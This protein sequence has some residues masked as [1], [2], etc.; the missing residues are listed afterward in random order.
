MSTKWQ[1]I[2]LLIVLLAAAPLGAQEK[3]SPKYVE[4]HAYTQLRFA[5]DF[6]NYTNFSVRRLKFWLSSGPDFSKHWSFK[7]QAIFMSIQK[8]KF[9]LQDVYGQYSWKN[10]S[11]R[12]GQFIPQFSLQRFQPD[13]LIPSS[14]R[15]RCVALLIP[16]ATLGARDIGL[17]YNL[18]AM[19]KKLEFNVGLFNGYGIK[20]YRF[21]NAG[22]MLTHNLSY[23]IPIKKS[24]LKLGYSV[25]YRKA[26]NIVFH[27]ILPDTV[28][29]SGDDFRFNF[30][31]IF[32]SKMVD[33]QAEYLQAILDTTTASGYYILATVKFNPKNQA[34]F[35]FD[36]YASKDS[37][38]LI[39]P[40]YIAGYNYLFKKHKI[41][42]SLESGFQKAGGQ[43][44]NRTVIQ[45]Q[46]FFH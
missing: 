11:I 29:Y 13:Y 32:T 17:Q 43:W 10:S 42:L 5:T 12:F 24:A 37:F 20:D 8:E 19:N 7:V 15:A 45:F 34:Y 3:A 16:D 38:P 27:G 22:F 21:N 4:W 44:Q 14:E 9:F 18:L 40:W 2:A 23:R 26:E 25:M 35:V 6:D 31:G 30:Y 33:V 28:N 36:E 39:A 46:L 1:N 41:M